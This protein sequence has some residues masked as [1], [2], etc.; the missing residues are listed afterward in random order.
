MDSPLCIPELLDKCLEFCNAASDLMACALVSRSWAAAAQL[1]LFEEISF[2]SH[3]DAERAWSQLQA[4]LDNSPHLLRYIH[5]LRIEPNPKWTETTSA[6]AICSFPWTH[7]QHV[8]I[9]LG[10]NPSIVA[11]QQLFS[12]PTLRSVKLMSYF[13]D[14]D[15][16]IW[17]RCSPSISSFDLTYSHKAAESVSQHTM[18]FIPEIRPESLRLS[19]TTSERLSQSLCPFDFSSLKRLSIDRHT[20]V[21]RWETIFPAFRTIIFLSFS[22]RLISKIHCHVECSSSFNF[23][24]QC[25]RQYRPLSVSKP[26]ASP[27]LPKSPPKAPESPRHPLH[28][29]F[30]Q[31]HSQ[32]CDLCSWSFGRLG[33]WTA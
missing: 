14:I 29:H 17:E 18:S 22:V 32:D 7:L 20:D 16:R 27:H 9:T 4:T 23:Q 5:S 19:V 30:L 21:L 1:R 8:H 28:D 15:G 6:A 3:N 26:R 2:R 33:V 24:G 10:M 11:I 13:D 12:L 25:S 31:S